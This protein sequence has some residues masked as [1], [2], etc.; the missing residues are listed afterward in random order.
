MKKCF[1]AK[2]CYQSCIWKCTIWNNKVKNGL[3]VYTGGRDPPLGFCVHPFFL[4]SHWGNKKES[5]TSA[6]SQSFLSSG[7]PRIAKC[8]HWFSVREKNTVE[9]VA[10]TQPPEN[11]SPNACSS[12]VMTECLGYFIP[13]IPPQWRTRRCC[14][15]ELYLLEWDSNLV[16]GQNLCRIHL[17]PQRQ[18]HSVPS[19]LLVPKY[20]W[21]VR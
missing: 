20:D 9:T 7:F 18:Y 16:L 4:L 14:S 21:R 15:P 11:T 10:L 17:P 13:A 6:L 2:Y 5:S 12:W 8:C 3:F 1:F 19:K